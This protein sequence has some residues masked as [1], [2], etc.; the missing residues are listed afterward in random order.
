MG[1]VDVER[2]RRELRRSFQLEL[3][4]AVR[5]RVERCTGELE[6]LALADVVP[7]LRQVMAGEVMPDAFELVAIAVACGCRV[8]DI[9]RDVGGTG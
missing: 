5:R 3:G 8:G 4:E 9:M 1:A 7:V 6:R 2:E